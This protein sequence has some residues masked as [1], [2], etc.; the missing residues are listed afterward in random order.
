MEYLK[1]IKIRAW[2]RVM[3][4]YGQ[5]LNPTRLQNKGIWFI[6]ERKEH[7]IKLSG[8]QPRFGEPEK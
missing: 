2:V 7:V 1:L 4:Y 6:V 5:Q 8:I 3:D